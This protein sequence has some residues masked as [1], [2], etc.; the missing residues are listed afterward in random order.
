MSIKKHASNADILSKTTLA[1]V[2]VGQSCVIAR[3]ELTGK[4]KARFAE[5]G[6]VPDTEVTVVRIAP[7]GDPMVVYARGFELCLRKDTAQQF[8]IR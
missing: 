4:V 8:I 5:M 7:L 3:C 1:D 6:L 2:D